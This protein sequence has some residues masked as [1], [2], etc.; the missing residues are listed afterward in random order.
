MLKMFWKTLI[1]AAGF[2]ATAGAPASAIGY[3][4]DAWL[5]RNLIIDR[6]G[7]CFGSALGQAL[8]DNSN[9][10]TSEPALSTE[11]TQIVSA[12]REGEARVGCS[13]NTGAG[14]SAEMRAAHAI[15]NALQDVPGRDELGWACWGYTGASVPVRAGASPGSPVIGTLQPGQSVVFEYWPRNGFAFATLVTGSGGSVLGQGWMEARITDADC[16]LVAG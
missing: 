8:F 10:T 6:Y 5:T 16:E 15:Y 9:C 14:P 12:I 7:Y 3:C 1:L 13:V 11:D 4:E 2:C